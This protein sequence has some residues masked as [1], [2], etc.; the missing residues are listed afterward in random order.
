MSASE[1][2]PNAQPKRHPLRLFL[3][4]DVM[5]GRGI[6]QIMKHPCNPT[7]HEN[8]VLS[9]VDYVHL[10][11]TTNGTI[12][13]RID[14]SYVWGVALDELN[15]MRPDARIVNLE[16]SVTRSEEYV[17]KDINY[18]MS[19]ENADCLKAAAVD[20]CVLGNNHV[21]DWGR[22]GLLDTIAALERLEIKTAG[23]GRDLTQTN[24]PAVLDIAS[25]GRVLVFSFA[26]TTSGV[27]RNW[28]ATAAVP[29]ISLLEG[30]PEAGAL[31]AADKIAGAK[32]A[33]DLVVVSVHWGPNWG[34]EIPDEHRK[35]AHTLIDKADVSIIHG[36]S[37]HHPKA[38]EVYRNRL[39]IYGCGD[40]L[41]DYE[42]ITGYEEYRD[43]LVL[44]YFA[45]FTNKELC[46]LEIVPLQ[47]RRFQLV[48]PSKED[49]G[50]MQRTLEREYRR[51]GIDVAL[52]DDRY[53][54]LS[55]RK[56]D[57]AHNRF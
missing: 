56:G 11:E 34:Y 9:A 52:T 35:F 49:I 18:R 44:M 32:N 45:D 41:N 7:L 42:G 27:P 46:G 50:W 40:F 37:S 38:I 31:G 14:P 21:L 25:K 30:T 2:S 23:A 8:G 33:G 29:G 20:C 26:S 16:T 51:F 36:H 39:I 24:A 5:T 48:R 1:P 6:D 12:P 47:I 10:A 43:D 57:Q 19:P 55:W 54:A 17:P 28:R 13:R 3:C 4:G 53:F 22:S 15:R